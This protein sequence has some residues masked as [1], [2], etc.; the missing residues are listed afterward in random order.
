MLMIWQVI[1]TVRKTPDLAHGKREIIYKSY[2][3]TPSGWMDCRDLAPGRAAG[4]SPDDNPGA[5]RF[6]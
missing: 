5:L 6:P 4:D 3:L 2:N 1:H